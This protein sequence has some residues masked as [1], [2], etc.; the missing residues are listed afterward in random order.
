MTVL[1]SHQKGRGVG[2]N[3]GSLSLEPTL[4]SMHMHRYEYTY[5]EIFKKLHQGAG[6]SQ[7]LYGKPYLNPFNKE[8]LNDLISPTGPLGNLRQGPALNGASLKWPP[9]EAAT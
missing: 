3:P 4:S 7:R 9:P 8:P 6:L 2:F 1:R 5:V